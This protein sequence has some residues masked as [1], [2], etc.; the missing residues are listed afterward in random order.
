MVTVSLGAKF[1]AMRDKAMPTVGRCQASRSGQGT[2]EGVAL[3][4]AILY[5]LSL[6]V[7][8]GEG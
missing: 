8:V 7:I 6:R 1:L 4:T 2:L 3:D 5:H